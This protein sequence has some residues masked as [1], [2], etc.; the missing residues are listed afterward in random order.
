[1]RFSEAF[2]RW[3]TNIL[4]ILLYAAVSTAAGAQYAAPVPQPS[5]PQAIPLAPPRTPQHAAETVP[6]RAT[7]GDTQVTTL[8]IAAS[9]AAY[10]TL[11]RPCACPYHKDR[12]GRSCGGRSA[13]SKP[14]GEAPL[15]FP[16]DITAGMIAAYRK[17]H[18]VTGGVRSAN[19][20]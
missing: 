12:G 13:H 9:I 19:L 14:G 20:K 1:M 10:F 17:G 3:R 11:N 7:L 2:M 15:C 16:T 18:T 5:A 6:D 4:V 8:I